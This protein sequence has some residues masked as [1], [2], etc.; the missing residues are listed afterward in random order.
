M[1]SQPRYLQ[2]N[3]RLE[4]GF[5][6]YS[7]IPRQNG[8]RFV[9]AACSGIGVSDKVS[10]VGYRVY[11]LPAETRSLF[12][13]AQLLNRPFNFCFSKFGLRRSGFL[14][15][16][17]VRPACWCIQSGRPFQ[18]LTNMSNESNL[19]RLRVVLLVCF[20]VSG[21]IENHGIARH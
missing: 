8:Y 11:G 15:H 14:V 20:V 9:H 4:P 7:V 3:K 17:P 2:S 12:A 21:T 18:T 1:R 10:R 16:C 13:H 6:P 19:R 5:E